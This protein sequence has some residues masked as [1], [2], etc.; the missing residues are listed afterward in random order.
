MSSDAMGG[1]INIIT[2]GFSNEFTGNINSYYTLAKHKG[3][4]NDY[5]LGL[6]LSGALIPDV[7]GFSLYGRYFHKF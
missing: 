4:G 3:I 5:S 6:Y 7:L 2:K 1:V